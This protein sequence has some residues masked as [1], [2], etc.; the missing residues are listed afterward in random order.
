MAVRTDIH[1]RLT[2]LVQALSSED[3]ELLSLAGPRDLMRVINAQLARRRQPAPSQVWNILLEWLEPASIATTSAGSSE[4]RELLLQPSGWSG[5]HVTWLLPEQSP[6]CTPESWLR[7]WAHAHLQVDIR[8]ARTATFEAVRRV[9]NRVNVR[10][11]R[12]APATAFARCG[13]CAQI[14]VAHRGI[15]AAVLE[16][17]APRGFFTGV[18]GHPPRAVVVCNGPMRRA[19]VSHIA[20]LRIAVPD[21]LSLAQGLRLGVTTTFQCEHGLDNLDNIRDCLWTTVR[22]KAIFNSGNI[23]CC[24]PHNSGP[25]AFVRQWQ[26]GDRIRV[27]LCHRRFLIAINGQ[28]S[29]SFSLPS[30]CVPDR[31]LDGPWWFVVDL[32]KA[33]I[34]VELC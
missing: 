17:Y 8:Q 9:S 14:D 33:V 22:G 26:S 28:D 5:L 10:T 3:L 18:P 13:V 19:G 27:E 2:L 20:E 4:L 11:W 16:Q 25:S 30:H 12:L 32:S 24:I 34:A 1:E 29:I 15:N 6:Q 21:Q 7:A 23:P 31:M